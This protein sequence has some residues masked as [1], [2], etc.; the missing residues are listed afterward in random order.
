MGLLPRKRKND[1]GPAGAKLTAKSEEESA[2]AD[3]ATACRSP[4]QEGE[5]ALVGA[6]SDKEGAGAAWVFLRTGTS[7]AQQGRSS[8]AKSG[9]ETTTGEFGKSVA[10]SGAGEYALIGGP[11]DKEGARRGV[12]VLPRKRENDLDPAGAKLSRKAGKRAATGEFGSSVAIAAKEGEYALIG[13]PGDKEG[14]G[15]AWV[16]FRERANELGPAG[17]EAHRRA[18]RAATGLFGFSV[19][20]SARRRTTR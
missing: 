8:S 2:P 13:G 17:R 16:F 18:A 6:P 20:L 5:Y 14:V 9:E 15:A 12:G 1:L 4:P 3:S 10:I 7:W 19:A 11:G